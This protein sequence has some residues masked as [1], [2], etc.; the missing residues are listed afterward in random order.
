MT[1]SASVLGT[2]EAGGMKVTR[3]AAVIKDGGGS[4]SIGVPMRCGEAGFRRVD[5]L[6]GSQ[7]FTVY[8]GTKI[9]ILVND[10]GKRE[11]LSI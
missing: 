11:A 6:G 4:E 2:I 9:F 8:V 3:E 7:N 1:N 10:D 5:T